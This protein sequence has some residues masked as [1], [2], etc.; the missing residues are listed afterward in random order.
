M[1]HTRVSRR[2]FGVLPDGRTVELFTIAG[3]HIELNAITYGGII[4]SLLVPDRTGQ[5]GDV[6]LGHAALDDYLR[7]PAYLGAVVGRYANRIA[8]GRFVLDGE[9][10]TLATNDNDHHLHGGRYGFDRQLWNAETF[11]SDT[12]AGVILSR[13]SPDGEEGYPGALDVTVRYL[14]PAARDA[15]EGGR[16]VVVEYEAACSRPTIVNLTQHTYFNLG[17]ETSASVLDHELQIDADRYT[18]VDPTL[19]PTGDLA[20]VAGTPFDFRSPARI[21]DRIDLRHQQIRQA[22]GFDHNFV[23]ADGD[24]ALAPAATLRDR[25]S[26]RALSVATTE[27]GLQFYSGQLL[28]GRT[29]GAYRRVHSAHAGLCLETQHFPDSPNHSHFPSV[30]L[31][32]GH[33]FR[34]TTVWRFWRFS[35]R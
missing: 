13:T 17:G 15:D 1:T 25:Q 23:L 34:S 29:I 5:M 14:V 6:V 12:E 28:D 30:V 16:S 20:P 19:I 8:Y 26:G 3:A 10:H 11:E 24:R 18:P 32:P 31:R 35:D 9:A 27:P 7:N 22:K 2:L 33:T 4:T 21:G